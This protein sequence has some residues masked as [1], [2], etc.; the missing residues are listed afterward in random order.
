MTQKADFNAEEWTLL[1]NAPALTAMLVIAA[2]KGGTV[3]ETLAVQRAYTAARAA[4]HGELLHEILNTPPAIDPATAPKTPD[5]LRREAPE[6]L[7]RAIALLERKATDEE[8]VEY[9]QFV[10]GLA[11]TVARAHREGGFLGIGGT[12]VSEHEQEALDEIA[13][14]FDE[15]HAT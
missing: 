15:K 13:A 3:R 14:I 6:T 8:V 5:E 4:E 1:A 9:K 2:D 12:E 10:F 7:R 11:D